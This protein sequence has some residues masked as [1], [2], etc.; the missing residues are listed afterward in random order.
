MTN[1]LYDEPGPRARRRALIGT[2]IAS[3]ALLALIGVAVKRLADRGQFDAELWSPLLNPSDDNFAAVW[4]LI[5]QGLTATVT[6]AALTIVLSLVLGTALGTARMLLGR[7]A[8]ADGFLIEHVFY[9]CSALPRI[10]V[11]FHGHR[12]VVMPSWWGE[13]RGSVIVR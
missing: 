8:N 6:A 7:W 12:V 4:R 3:A 11:T 10:G 2:I 13:L 1:V 5:G 9:I